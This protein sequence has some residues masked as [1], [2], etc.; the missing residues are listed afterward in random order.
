ML[1]KLD[2]TARILLA[3]S[4]FT[5]ALL[6]TGCGIT[7]ELEKPGT[8]PVP[9]DQALMQMQSDLS[10]VNIVVPGTLLLADTTT[11]HLEDTPEAKAIEAVIADSQCFDIDPTTGQRNPNLRKINP[12]IPVS[13]GPLQLQVQGQLSESGTFTV[14]A[15]PSIGGTV[16]RQ[17][18]Q[19]VMVPLTLVSLLTIS[20]FYVGQQFTN[21]QYVTLVDAY[22]PAN[23][24]VADSQHKQIADYIT[25]TLD[26]A[27]RLDS[28]VKKSLSEFRSHPNSWCD[29]HEDGKPQWFGPA[30]PEQPA[31]PASH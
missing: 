6:I 3:A 13:T 28:I 9:I 10:R 29:G 8:K 2:H 17:A 31:A 7:N 19:Q 4:I 20:E 5:S 12:L 25:R 15:T 30:A 21:I 18:Q 16:Q 1:T 24:N 11:V 22:K 26:V 14:S 27:A 23:S